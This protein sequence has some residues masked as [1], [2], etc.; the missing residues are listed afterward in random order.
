[1]MASRISDEEFRRAGA[2]VGARCGLRFDEA[3][4]PILEQ[5]LERAAQGEQTP[6]SELLDRLQSAPSDAL[7]Q[8]VLR[9]VTIGETYLFRHPEH[10]A[11]VRDVVVPERMRARSVGKELRGWS[12]ACATGE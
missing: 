12:A 4:R 8:S 9:Q 1:M 6:P 10:F 11:A 5:G 3:N 7:V 2:L